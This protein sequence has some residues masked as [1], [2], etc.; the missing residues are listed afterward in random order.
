MI[1]K[2]LNVTDTDVPDTCLQL[3][4]I[5]IFEIVLI[6]VVVHKSHIGCIKHD[7]CLTVFVKWIIV[8]L[9]GMNIL[10]GGHL[11]LGLG[12]LPCIQIIDERE[13]E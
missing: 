8:H 11:A 13:P 10:V 4:A 5:L 1:L 3:A 12:L 2:S 7:L 6:I 9:S